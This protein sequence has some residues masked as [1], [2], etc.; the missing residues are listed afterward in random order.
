M[1][2]PPTLTDAERQLIRGI[3]KLATTPLWRHALG[4][5]M[6]LI[7]G[8]SV[9]LYLG[10]LPSH[11]DITGIALCERHR[12]VWIPLGEGTE[13]LR[14]LLQIPS[15]LIVMGTLFFGFIIWMQFLQARR[16]H[17]LL[18]KVFPESETAPAG[19]KPTDPGALESY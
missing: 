1:N 2:P 12:S 9:G 13:A 19:P 16:L 8:L 7:Y 6:L 11:Y 4:L 10:W 17:A 14:K 5:S 15:S 3:A 18:S